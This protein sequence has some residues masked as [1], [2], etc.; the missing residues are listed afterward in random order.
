MNRRSSDEFVLRQASNKSGVPMTSEEV[1]RIIRE[2]TVSA[3]DVERIFERSLTRVLQ[4]YGVN[5]KEP[6]EQQQDLHH[7]HNQRLASEKVSEWV[8]KGIFTTLITGAI[9]I[10]IIGARM[11][12][13][14]FM[15][16]S[17]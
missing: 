15:K 1:R 7:L 8:R 6:H 5:V 17:Q 10:F 13:Q 11:A 16:G 3:E 4:S 12:A 14:N 2:E 9:G